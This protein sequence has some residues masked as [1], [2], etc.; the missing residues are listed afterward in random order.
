MKKIAVIIGAVLLVASLF[1]QMAIAEQEPVELTQK[2]DV[3]Q[4]LSYNKGSY[5]VREI[6]YW[7]NVST[8]MRMKFSTNGGGVNYRADWYIDGNFLGSTTDTIAIENY[9]FTIGKGS[10]N[11]LIKW[12]IS[13]T[14]SGN[15]NINA[16]ARYILQYRDGTVGVVDADMETTNL[17]VNR[18]NQP[19]SKPTYNSPVNGATNRDINA[20]LFWSCTDPNG[21][22]LTYDVYF[23]TAAT[24]PKVATVSTTTYEPGAL[25]YSTKYYWK[26]VAKDNEGAARE[27]DIW[28]FTTAAQSV[29]QP[30]TCSLSVN[31]TAGNSPLTVA[32]AMA[33]S[34]PDGTIALWR[35]DINNDGSPEY[36]G[37]GSP[38]ATKQHTYTAVGTYTASLTVIDNNGTSKSAVTTITVNRLPT[39][40]LSASP[41]HGNPP[42]DVEFSMSADDTDG[43][44]FSW[45][46]DVNNDGIPEYSGSGVPPATQQHTYNSPGNYIANLTVTDDRQGSA[47][48]TVT[49]RVNRN[50]NKPSNINPVN[51]AIDID[52]NADL[53]WQ[54]TD[55]NGDTLTYDVYFGTAATPPK[56]ATVST[57]TYE[58]GALAY[59]T[60]YYW[61]IVAKDAGGLTNES[62]IWSF[63]TIGEGQPQ[64][65]APTKPSISEQPTS[66]YPNIDY[67]FSISSSDPD[68][69]G[70]K[71]I[72][73]WIGDG[74]SFETTGYYPSGQTAVLS[75]T[76]DEAWTYYITVTA[77]D[78]KG[79]Q[80]EAATHKIMI[81]E[82]IYAA[83]S[84]GDGLPD[85]IEKIIDTDENV[86]N[87]VVNITEKT[88][89][90]IKGYLVLDNLVLDNLVLDKSIYYDISRNNMT[91]V[92]KQDVNGDG[93]DDYVFDSDGDG[94]Y[95]HWY[96]GKTG[97][98]KPY[99]P[100]KPFDWWYLI[101]IACFTAAVIIAIYGVKRLRR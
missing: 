5:G 13:N 88:G 76:W 65:R 46:L 93:T 90:E 37:T 45:S 23:G 1:L 55:P 9:S 78:E 3:N 41:S 60:K 83:D 89:G 57:T 74:K 82:K 24:P 54:C 56:V 12:N 38:P 17:A 59:S 11:L 70:I 28:S 75:H 40:S 36:S 10:H 66:G 84:D 58:P 63:T 19:P 99:E 81:S 48:A 87:T 77:M 47:Y 53:S 51:D 71:Y 49:I 61:K 44:I 15:Y 92:R 95:D 35:L 79:A 22:A 97:E 68:E 14:P 2:E 39:C 26:I 72:I 50:P 94:K 6:K 16:F 31:P 42:L 64:N 29:N 91:S 62:D 85:D 4:S 80:S 33:A 101:V 86:K 73:D 21:D 20:D 67:A 43:T 32:F 100:A 30:P 8:D 98:V 34:D 25:A 52:V 69:D 96:D 27:G 18:T 7:L